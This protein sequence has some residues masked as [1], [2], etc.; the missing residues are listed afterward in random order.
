[1]SEVI[2]FAAL[3][4]GLFVV[5]TLLLSIDQWKWPKSPFMRSLLAVLLVAFE[6]VAALWL[7]W[8]FMP[9]S[10][11]L[12]STTLACTHFAFLCFWCT[13]SRAPSG[14]RVI[15]LF[16]VTAALFAIFNLPREWTHTDSYAN[17]N[18]S[19]SI[20][21][22]IVTALGAVVCGACCRLRGWR[23]E[24][25][26]RQPEERKSPHRATSVQSL[27]TG[28]LISLAV[29]AIVGVKRVVESQ[30][31]DT[32]QNDFSIVI[33]ACFV[34]GLL[35]AGLAITAC[36]FRFEWLGGIAVGFAIL[37][38]VVNMSSHYQSWTVMQLKPELWRQYLPGCC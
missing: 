27:M 13:C 16:L 32:F 26:E 9:S 8:R 2:C 20:Y 14:L 21:R 1:M 17:A 5:A 28:L 34:A 36:Q 10:Y 38:S 3:L 12:I 35:L 31:T 33:F 6:L 15:L 18:V 19:R 24:N 7:G 23:F 30:W 37:W 4:G 11:E 25:K 29:F 22:L